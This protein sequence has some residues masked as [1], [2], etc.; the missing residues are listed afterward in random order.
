MMGDSFFCPYCDSEYCRCLSVGT[1]ATQGLP[2]IPDESNL[3]EVDAPPSIK[4]RLDAGD[5]DLERIS[6]TAWDALRASNDPHVRIVRVGGIPSRLETG[7]D[8]APE[9]KILTASRLR[10]EMAACAEWYRMTS[11]GEEQPARPPRDVAENMLAQPN[12]RLPILERIV[13]APV[14]SPDG[15]IETRPGYH[16]AA[17]TYYSGGVELRPVS[18]DPTSSEQERA[19]EWIDNLLCDF[20][21]VTES[22]KLIAVAAMLG[23]FVRSL[24]TGSTPLHLF[25]APTPG[26]GKGLLADVVA[27]P[28]TG[29]RAA[30]ITEARNEEEW[31][32]RITAMLRNGRAI[33]L[34]D[35][36][37]GRLESAAL[38]AAL[39]SPLWTDRILGQ[40]EI[41]AYP[42]RTT[43][44]ATGNN[45]GMSREI[46]RRTVRCRMDSGEE[47]P[48]DRTGFRYELPGW[49]YLHRAELVWSL[50]TLVQSWLAG[51]AKPWSGTP[52][53]SLES[54]C[55]TIGGILENGGLQDFLGN[56]EAF[57]AEADEETVAWSAFVESWWAKFSNQE[58]HAGD[59]FE[60][61]LQHIDLGTG[62]R[63]SQQTRVG[64]QLAHQRDRRYDNHLIRRR[65][66]KDGRRMWS[67]EVRT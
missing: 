25:E 50:L 20:P 11:K 8:G 38:S 56:L 52:L 59:L 64:T 5:Q 54:W 36:L 45:P 47:H 43:W 29:R 26:T 40:S 18:E 61:A 41:V 16:S 34:L 28:S 53:G 10:Q 6:S 30:T 23:P 3:V 15:V 44:L 66:L 12:I 14:F 33:T 55:R 42:V 49:A 60:I 27:I 7:D 58:V 63:R 17:R 13:E 4:P 32:K 31:R 21:F 2:D 9:V 48:E 24:I 22:D 37:T 57:R 1:V 62:T 46:A 35:N 39:T 51:G 65:G 67:L 19:L